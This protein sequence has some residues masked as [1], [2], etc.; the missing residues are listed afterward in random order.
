MNLVKMI[1]SKYRYVP[2]IY[3]GLSGGIVWCAKVRSYFDPDLWRIHK[4]IY[5]YEYLP[6]YIY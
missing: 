1:L 3:R 2:I 5:I 6:L 4:N